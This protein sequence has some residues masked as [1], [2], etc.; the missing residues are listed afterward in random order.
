MYTSGLA[1]AV[2]LSSI[3]EYIDTQLNQWFQLF[4]HVVCGYVE[5][6]IYGIASISLI[7]DDNSV[8]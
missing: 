7:I 1:A 2:I 5:M 3:E 6:S 8:F 4:K